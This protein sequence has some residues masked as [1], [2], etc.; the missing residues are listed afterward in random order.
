MNQII[1]S[2]V[3]SSEAS[4]ESEKVESISRMVCVPFSVKAVQQLSVFELEPTKQTVRTFVHK[5]PDPTHSTPT[6]D[7]VWVNVHFLF[8]T[9][10]IPTIYFER[11]I[12]Y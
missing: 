1:E 12:I 10:W 11:L 8:R 6:T 7:S 3:I 4:A 2:F 9:E 5:S